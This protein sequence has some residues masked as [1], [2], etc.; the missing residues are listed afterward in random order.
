M[1]ACNINC[2]YCSVF[3]N[4]HWSGSGGVRQHENTVA[5]L[6][7]AAFSLN[8]Q[9]NMSPRKQYTTTVTAGGCKQVVKVVKQKGVI[10]EERN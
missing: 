9:S 4:K 8:K 3:S 6:P 5:N 10:S 7:F 2:F 1:N